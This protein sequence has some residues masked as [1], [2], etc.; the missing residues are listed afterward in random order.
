[1]AAGDPHGGDTLDAVRLLRDEIFQAYIIVVLLA[2]AAV[3]L[4]VLLFWPAM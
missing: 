4:P 2:I 1:M 3:A